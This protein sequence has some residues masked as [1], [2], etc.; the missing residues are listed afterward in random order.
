[1]KYL[2][3]TRVAT[4]AFIYFVINKLNPVLSAPLSIFAKIIHEWGHSVGAFLTG[5]TVEGYSLSGESAA[6]FACTRGGVPWFVLIM[7]NVIS[8][9]AAIL[10]VEMGRRSERYF[11]S[12]LIV[13]GVFMVFI[14]YFIADERILAMP[15]VV[16]YLLLFLYFILT[17]RVHWAE[18]FTIFFGFLNIWQVVFDMLYGGV[19]S[20]SMRFHSLYPNL[21]IVV[22]VFFWFGISGFTAYQLFTNVAETK[23]H[24]A[25]NTYRIFNN[26][27]TQKVLLF[28]SILP[29][30]ILFAGDQLLEFIIIQSSRIFDFRKR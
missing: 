8:L 23:V 5:G 22:W 10:F 28:I 11:T 19:L 12:M 14:T 16:L 20:D 21:P 9:S 4:V 27:D 7:G 15:I 24:W 3:L 6:L 25:A 26:I 17:K 1:M 29:H 18:A 30:F 2:L 13:M